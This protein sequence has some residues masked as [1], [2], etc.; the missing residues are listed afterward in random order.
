MLKE[1]RD[2]IDAQVRAG[3]AGGGAEALEQRFGI[4]EAGVADVAA[5]SVGDHR[6]MGRN[7]SDQR[8][9]GMPAL[10]APTL[11]EGEVWLVGAYQIGGCFD[12]SLT[13]VEHAIRRTHRFG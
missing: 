2:C 9:Q 11:E 8:L 1:R 13:E 6:D 4:G 5:L 10:G 7:R 3:S 12:D